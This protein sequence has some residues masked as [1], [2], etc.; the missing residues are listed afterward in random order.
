MYSRRRFADSE[1]IAVHAH[2]ATSIRVVTVHN[3]SPLA[4]V[5]E[6]L[7]TVEAR[8]ATLADLDALMVRD[9]YSR[10]V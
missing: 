7:P 10:T 8:A 9:G 5:V 2:G 4:D 3:G 6:D 1:T